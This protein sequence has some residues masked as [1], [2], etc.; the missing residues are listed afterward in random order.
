MIYWEVIYSTVWVYR[1][2][3]DKIRGN[4]FFELFRLTHRPSD[5]GGPT[6]VVSDIR[7]ELRWVWSY[8]N[9]HH[10]RWR[11]W[12]VAFCERVIIT[13]RFL[14]ICGACEEV[15]KNWFG[16][17]YYKNAFIFSVIHFDRTPE[18]SVFELEQF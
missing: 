14:K 9:S 18:L 11:S 4:K 1:V 3:E 10:R 15:Y 8:M 13:F 12:Y 5:E 6:G 2:S 7:V 17:L 16:Y